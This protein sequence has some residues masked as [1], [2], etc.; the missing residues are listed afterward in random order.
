MSNPL[1]DA[2]RLS[3][4]SG[5]PCAFCLEWPGSSRG[6]HTL[7]CPMLSMPKIIKALELV[8]WYGIVFEEQ[9]D[10]LHLITS[11]RKQRR[12]SERMVRVLEAAKAIR[13]WAASDPNAYFG[14]GVL[15]DLITDLVDAMQEEVAQPNEPVLTGS[16][17]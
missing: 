12:I 14:D 1:D 4:G 9:E 8:E 15:K 10:G 6:P 2:R 5:D 17:P 13:A 3:E 7:E 16:G 11:P